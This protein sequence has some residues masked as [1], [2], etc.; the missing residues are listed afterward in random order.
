M[1]VRQLPVLF[2]CAL[3]FALAACGGGGSTAPENGVLPVAS[4]DPHAP[5][6][7][8]TAT[9]TP[10]PV[11]TSTSGTGTAS[12]RI[13]N[14][15]GRIGL[16]QVFDYHN[17]YMPAAT[18]DQHAGKIDAVWASLEAGSWRAAHPG[19]LVSQYFI[20]GL[21]QHSVTH[22]TLT[23]WQRNH[24]DW[25]LYA[26]SANGSPTH[27]VA[28]MG[29]IGVPDV[30]LDIHDAGAVAYQVGSMAK[31]A[32]DGGYNALAIDQVVFWN[33]YEGG[34]PNFGQ[35]VK[36]GEYGCGVWKGSTFDRL[37]ASPAD[38]RYAADVV[39]YVA[40]ARSIAHSY[41]LTLMV[42]HP[43]GSVSS[44]LEQQLL[45]NTD[46]DLD[47]TGFSDYGRYVAGD[48]GIFK[49]ELSYIRY[50]QQHGTGMMII[51]KFSNERHVDPTGLEYSLATYLLGNEGGLLLFV[52]GANDY[53]TMQYHSE[54]DA[55][56]GRPCGAVS[57]GPAV[58]GRR[59]SGGLAVVNA[60]AD[61]QTVRLPSSGY[62]DIE[63]RAVS[64]STL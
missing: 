49:R 48:G 47:E 40:Q 26:C 28:Y 25:I 32:K 12:T 22:H 58:Y 36:S 50:A 62:R 33:I 10:I 37:Y 30:P 52:G 4:A 27:D 56:I 54:Y 17:G 53:G 63:G 57:G 7:A 15:A 44:A 14:T 59:F 46:I 8:P 19:M 43:A 11:P 51:D 31:A 45:R 35:S 5:V 34:N 42:N 13:P 1:R 3:A 55:R 61:S 60:S 9:A 23:W 16:L 41:G 39:N 2:A 24:P 20:M 64:G 18:I 21:D 6:P 29:G 38:P